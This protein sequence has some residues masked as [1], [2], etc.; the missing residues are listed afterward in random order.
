MYT[1][2]ENIDEYNQ[3]EKCKI[4]IAFDDMIADMFSNIKLNPVVTELFIRGCKLN[5]SLVFITQSYFAVTKNICL[6]STHYFKMKIP[7]NKSFKKSL[8]II[9]KI[10]TLKTLGSFIKNKNKLRNQIFS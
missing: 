1:I 4:L 8:L 2:Y 10:L 3:N 7:K 9:H 5:I 6:N